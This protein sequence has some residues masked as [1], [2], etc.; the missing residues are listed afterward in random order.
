MGLFGK[1]EDRYQITVNFEQRVSLEND[2]LPILFDQCKANG[3]PII[4]EP[5]FSGYADQTWVAF[6]F[7]DFD[8]NLTFF[9]NNNSVMISFTRSISSTTTEEALASAIIGFLQGLA[10]VPIACTFSAEK[11]GKKKYTYEKWDRIYPERRTYM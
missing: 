6:K 4:Q 1:K 5:N 8:G 10:N 3:F 2:V 11:E 7:Q 9:N